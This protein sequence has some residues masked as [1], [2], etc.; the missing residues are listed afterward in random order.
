MTAWP[1]APIY[2]KGHEQRTTHWHMQNKKLSI[3]I[4]NWNTSDLLKQCLD[5]LFKSG[6]IEHDVIVVDN[7]STDSSVM[8]VEEMF[9]AATLIKNEANLGF[10]K[11]NNIAIER[12]DSDYVCLLNSD[13][14]VSPDCFDSML[15]F[16]DSHTDAVACAPALRLPDGK[17]Q[18]GGAGFEFS[19]STA[20]NYF[21]FL[22]KIA[23]FR[24]RGF[25]VD[26]GAYVRSG[27]PARVGWLAGACMMVRKS[28]IDAVGALDDSLFM[29]AEDAEWCDRLR[30]VGGIYFL[31]GLEIIHYHGA[32]SKNSDTVST[33]WLD[34][35]FKY[36]RSKHNCTQSQIFRAIAGCG[37]LIRMIIFYALSL[38]D[39]GWSPNRK[40]MTT[41]LLFTLK[42]K[43]D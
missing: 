5:S 38:K 41:Y 32:S 2:G 43:F 6:P 12:I 28:A 21:F 9:P 29:Y 22:S 24:C 8:M 23:P 30:T 33:K 34:A 40:A 27:Q 17:L 1:I 20:F 31:P 39:D 26:Q 7:G 18:T 13:T 16:M 42:W 36:F 10:A 25:F 15:R 4:V 35:T 37:F 11:A 19:V 3:V 14:V